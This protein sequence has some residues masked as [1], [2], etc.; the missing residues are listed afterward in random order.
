MAKPKISMPNMPTATAVPATA[1]EPQF[2]F[3]PMGRDEAPDNRKAILADYRLAMNVT[4]AKGNTT[5]HIDKMSD[6]TLWRTIRQVEGEG[7]QAEQ[8]RIALLFSW[9]ATTDKTDKDAVNAPR[10]D[11]APDSAIAFAKA[12]EADASAMAHLKAGDDADAVVKATTMTMVTDLRRLIKAGTI[13]LDDMPVVNSRFDQAPYNEAGYN[14][15]LPD[16]YKLVDMVTGAETKGR[17]TADVYDNLSYGLLNRRVNDAVKAFAKNGAGLGSLTAEQRKETNA[18]LSE[19]GVTCDKMAKD[20][21][22]RRNA[23]KE[24]NRKRNLQ[25]RFL[26]Q[27][28]Q[29][30]QLVS[31]V[32]ST[33]PNIKVREVSTDPA[34]V[35]RSAYPIRFGTLIRD[36]NDEVVDTLNTEAITLTAFLKVNL[37]LAVKAA[38]QHTPKLSEDLSEVTGGDLLASCQPQP[39]PEGDPNAASGKNMPTTIG[40]EQLEVTSI[41]LRNFFDSHSDGYEKRVGDFSRM[42]GADDGGDVRVETFGDALYSARAWFDSTYGAAYKAIKDKRTK[43]DADKVAKRQASAARSKAFVDAKAKLAIKG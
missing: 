15:P 30:L 1:G 16:Y 37:V 21:D 35:A 10:V 27:A 26:R 6:S 19:I 17:W 36:D 13:D 43:D 22:A 4:D 29:Y 9:D 8:D 11:H 42:L 2:G 3:N 28:V 32:H 18:Y 7:E 33:F 41:Q 23:V 25:T 40:P 34:E 39:E 31:L 5:N 12:I 20:T 14:G 38:E 24:I